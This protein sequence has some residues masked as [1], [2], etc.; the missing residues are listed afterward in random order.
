MAEFWSVPSPNPPDGG[1]EICL[2]K[3][4]PPLI[5]C[6]ARSSTTPE[7]RF[8]QAERPHTVGEAAAT[9]EI[10]TAAGVGSSGTVEMKLE[11]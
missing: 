6:A 2:D 9:N 1:A 3:L 10:V 7:K 11:C 4:S 8:G 5:T